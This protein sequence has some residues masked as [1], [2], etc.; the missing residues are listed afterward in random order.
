MHFDAF[1]SRYTKISH[2]AQAFGLFS[3]VQLKVSI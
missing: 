1:S 2:F 3:I